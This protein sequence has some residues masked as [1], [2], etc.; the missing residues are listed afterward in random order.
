MG[1]KAYRV[2]P[3]QPGCR[4]SYSDFGTRLFCVC[5][6]NHTITTH[7]SENGPDGTIGHRPYGKEN[8]N[9]EKKRTV[10]GFRKNNPGEARSLAASRLETFPKGMEVVMLR[11]CFSMLMAVSLLLSFGMANAGTVTPIFSFDDMT[12]NA[13]SN[14]LAQPSSA[15]SV[16]PY[17]DYGAD[18]YEGWKSTSN[19][20]SFYRYVIWD[21]NSHMGYPYY[22]LLEIDN[23]VSLKGNALKCTITGGNNAANPSGIGL[24]VSNKSQYVAQKNS[25]YTN[26]VVGDPY[27]YFLANRNWSPNAPPQ[28][29]F[30][31]APSNANRLS[32]YVKAP[33][34][35]SV[36]QGARRPQE[37]WSVGPYSNKAPGGGAST[38]GHFYHDIPVGGGGWTKLQLDNHPRYH[39]AGVTIQQSIPGYI[40]AITGF[41]ITGANYEGQI[42]TP[43][44]LWFDEIQFEY[45]DYAPQNNETINS[46]SV[47]YNDSANTWEVGFHDKYQ[48]HVYYNKAKATYEIRYSFGPITNENWASATPASIQ[49]YTNFGI[50]ARTDGRFKRVSN[51]DYQMVW[52]R[53]KLASAADDATFAAN[54]RIYFA[55]KDVSQDPANLRNINPALTGTLA[56]QGRDYSGASSVFNDYTTDAASLPYIKRIDFAL[57]G[58]SSAPADTTAPVVTAFAIPAT[59]SALS[60]PVTSFTATDTVGVTGYLITESSTPP[61]AGAAG[62]SVSAPAT[63]IATSTGNHTL[64]PWTKDAAG[65]VSAVFG[66]PATVTITIVD[67]TA[68]TVSISSPANNA[69]VSGAVSVS[70]AAADNT[71]VS[72]VEFYVN[73]TLQASDTAS[74]F[75]FNW[76]TTS[77]ANGAYTLSAKAYDDAGNAG[78][79]GNLSVTVANDTTM[80]TVSVTAP[81]SNA[82]LSGTVAV[83]AAASDNTGVSR[84]EIYANGAMLYVTNVAPYSYSWNTTSVAN[85]S[86]TITAK[87]Y[88]A[89]GNMAQ[90]AAVTVTVNNQVADTTAPTV[91]TFSVPATA[92]SLIVPITTFTATDNV[93]VTGYLVTESAT[94]P[95]AN[96]AWTSPAPAGYTFATAG[97]KTLYAWVKDAAGN[98]SASQSATVTVT[99]TTSA[100]TADPLA[101][102][103]TQSILGYLINLP[104]ASTNKVVSG[105]HTYVSDN[106]ISSIYSSTGKYPGLVGIDYLDQNSSAGNN[107][108]ISQSNGNGL[109]TVLHHWRN[110]VS[111]GDAWD[112]SNVDLVQ[113]VTPGTALNTKFNGY[114]DAVATGLQTLQSNNVTVLYRP[115]HEMNGSWF[116]WGGK[117]ATQ[118]KNV[119]KY[120]FNYM[121]QAKGLH[122]LLWVYG[123]NAG[124]NMTAYYPG[125]QYVDVVG[126]DLYG[127]PS[128]SNTADYNALVAL[129]KPFGLTEYGP[130]GSSGCSASVD[131]TPFISSLK[132]A[133]PKTT[134]WMNWAG[135]FSMKAN[136]G[137]STVLSDPWV[138]TRDEMPVLGGTNTNAPVTAVTAPTANTSV[139]GTV[140]VTAT[141]ADTVGITSVEFYVNG[142]LMATDTTAPYSY[143]WDTTASANGSATLSTKAYNAAGSMAQSS[144]VTVTVNNLAGDATPPVVSIIEPGT[145]WN[146][147]GTISFSA[148]ATDN[149]GVTKLE[150]Y[151]DGKLLYTYAGPSYLYRWDTTAVSNGSHILTVKGYDASGNVGQSAAVTIN[152]T[153]TVSDTTA[154]ATALSAPAANASVSGT[155]SVTATA[156][157]AVGVTK[158]EFYVSGVLKATDTTSPYS[159][160]WDTTTAANGTATLSTKA[161][162]A[163]GNAGQSAGRTVT[164][165]NDKTAPT[166]SAFAIPSSASSLTVAVTALTASDNVSVTGYLV[167]ESSAVPTT[168]STGWTSTPQSSYTFTSEGSKTLYAWAK[169]AAGNVSAAKSALVTITL[170]KTYYVSPV[171]SDTN[172][173]SQAQPCRELAKPLTLIKAGD[174]VLMADGQYQGLDIVGITGT[175]QAP[176]I[177][178]A[179]GSGA[180]IGKRAN[181]IGSLFLINCSYVIFDGIKM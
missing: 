134:F 140:S 92:S 20:M 161:Y 120:V 51:D 16:A 171:G 35:I 57:P 143:T 80:P 166:V 12:V 152:V 119:W 14:T 29:T 122:N 97:N 98:V 118:F 131:W 83:T 1:R 6:L 23:L 96:A 58:T 90:S 76:S 136:T 94:P 141:A 75:T 144:A 55:V 13:N 158:V 107:L 27:L 165:N 116:W 37:T 77:L 164:V 89:A 71:G 157:D 127:S 18:N 151:A 108:A 72:K 85:G 30:P 172:S 42:M 44:S 62:W 167:T 81:V 121:T 112:T 146:M 149:V 155:V 177:I 180:Y 135:T 68:P 4:K 123:P 129:N 84:I 154:P 178:K 64:Y 87:A 125:S 78:Q 28:Q 45:D 19:N 114:L 175:A 113:L 132:T 179:Q 133:M 5:D 36:D 17:N 126:M 160:S 59:A 2:S 103:K 137:T 102:P 100:V 159:F 95:A 39:N 26:V 47:G 101:N 25:S 91:T 142:L 32:M 88:D 67:T 124:L 106:L 33:A 21:N 34:G 162:D 9:A 93:A 11:R 31:M 74:P 109:V 49:A 22:G 43:Y 50:E 111:D 104:N 86:V 8:D 173:C 7:E 130:C 79:S 41:Y 145:N 15:W 128:V 174:T 168:A 156:T 163:A 181:G 169:D 105:Q 82:T 52:S 60:V 53:F 70:I 138:L 147:N 48:D 176:I 3:R 150:Y 99:A 24:K 46:L 61:S 170:P 117:D 153:N 54:K 56:G 115:F 139:N 40:P 69:S 66:S 148:S 10:D 110:P 63:Y 65:N 73:G 38:G